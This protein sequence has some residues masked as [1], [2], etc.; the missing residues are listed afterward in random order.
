VSHLFSDKTGTLTQNIMIFR[1]YCVNG[2]IFD[3]EHLGSEDW[4]LFTM[5]MSLCHSVEY[6]SGH[7]V[8]SSPDEKAI[9]ESCNW[10]GFSFCGEELDG[11]VTIS[12]KNHIHTYKKLAELQFDSYRKCMSVIVRSKHVFSSEEDVIYVFVKGAETSVLPQCTSGPIQETQKIVDNFA[13][14][15]LRTLVYGYKVITREELQTFSDSLEM[16]K[17]S[18]VNR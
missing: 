9:V 10:A 8:A 1:Q 12:A 15:G 18:I 6:T 14:E 7:F 4:D 3:L 13:R 16:A 17:Q 5:A 2:K 11:T